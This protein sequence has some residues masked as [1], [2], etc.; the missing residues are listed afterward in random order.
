MAYYWQLAYQDLHAQAAGTQP[1]HHC[2]PTDHHISCPICSGSKSP[3]GHSAQKYHQKVLCLH[4][5][6]KRLGLGL[7]LQ[8]TETISKS[9]LANK[10]FVYQ[11]MSRSNLQLASCMHATCSQ[12]ASSNL[13]LLQ[14]APSSNLQLLQ[15]V[16]SLASYGLT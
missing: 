4:L 1:W 2:H 10:Q 16:S 9:A 14:L 5:H 13:Q 11:L 15:L 3:L 12:L 7:A 8:E 6:R